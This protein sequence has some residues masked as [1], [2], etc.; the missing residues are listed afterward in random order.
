[1][2]AKYNHEDLY[3][4]EA[5]VSESERELWRCY[6]AGFKKRGSGHDAGNLLKLNKAK[7]MDSPIEHPEKSQPSYTLILAQ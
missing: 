1:M 7:K 3:K 2:R 4:R 5:G 6:A